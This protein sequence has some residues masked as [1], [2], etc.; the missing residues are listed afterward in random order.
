M[1]N[2]KAWVSRHNPVLT[3]P[4]A[5]APLTVGNGSVAMSVDVTGLQTLYEDYAVET[6]LCTMANWGWHTIPASTPSGAYTLRDVEMDTYD[7]C[8]REVTYART[9]H[10]GNEHV[11][12]W[13]R[14][15]P[16]K[17]SMVRA[18][19]RLHG[20]ELHTQDF[21]Q[22]HQELHLYDGCI[23]SSY[24][25]RGEACQ[26]LTACDSDSDTLVFR[27]ASPLL[28]KGLTVDLD[29]PY[30]AGN[31]T[32]ADWT[33]P[34]RHVT[35]LEGDIIRREM[36]AL[37][38]TLRI[39]APGA[40]LEQTA[41]HRIRI[42]AGSDEIVIALTLA[43]GDPAAADGSEAILRGQKM[44]NAFW[45]K[46]GAIDFAQAEDPRAMELERRIIL[47]LYLLTI[48][49]SGTVPPA[50]T[51]LTCNS[52]FG[53][54]HLEMHFWHMAW[55]PLWGHRELLERGIPWYREHLPEARANAARNLYKGAR[56]PKMVG[57]DA[58]DSP[59][60]VAV[61][62]IWQ[63]PHIITMLE[64][65]R[66][67]R[68]AEGDPA[69]DEFLRE[70]WPLVKETADFMA[71]YAMPVPD[72]GLFHIAPPLIPVQER[73]LPEVTRD[74][75][76]EVAY[77]KFGLGVAIHWAELLGAE[78]DGRWIEVHARM[79][80][81]PVHHGVYTAHADCPETFEKVAIDHPSMLQCMGMLPGV[82]IDRE[83]MTRTLDTVI[84]CWDYG[85]LWGWDFAVM[86]MTA[87]RLDRPGVALDQLLCQTN[88]NTY[89]AS[90]NNRQIT[91]RD[92]PL[93]LPGN[94]SLLLAAAMMAAGWD[95]GK[96]L[97][98]FPESEGW[99]VAAE[100]I[101][102]YF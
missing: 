72:D 22:V 10:P 17:F 75:S 46:G 3:Q 101:H 48:N 15:N 52:W 19:L 102:P 83:T 24:L 39:S 5:L 23:R 67:A 87:A 69:M 35:R 33:S 31:I 53:K 49:S 92:L 80:P 84:G 79:A 90:G 70:N 56:W 9:K 93:Y 60:N 25:L 36:D 65:I 7:F 44:W 32:G 62:L 2:R 26:V 77:W 4:D 94:G 1:I 81:P 63:Q 100:G 30:G 91:R 43:S 74:P 20:E 27:I 88:K 82:D 86:A 18:S 76:F 38:Y 28:T 96:P 45:E 64:L 14:M 61:V 40:A 98:G 73:H 50:E 8:G 13:L 99:Q 12:D 85:T 57:D 29:F 42:T 47:S 58:L 89:V 71:D 55:A 59:S 16:H 34:E 41:A 66:R 97:P 95:G 6:P 68:A 37:R 21:T 78:P 11:Y 54:A 51:G